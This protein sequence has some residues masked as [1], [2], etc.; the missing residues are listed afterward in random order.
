MHI[1][2]SAGVQCWLV[3]LTHPDSHKW[4]VLGSF[5]SLE[6]ALEYAYQLTN[7]EVMVDGKRRPS[8]VK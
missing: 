5:Q 4:Q 7:L 1:H 2:V 3:M 6:K 8:D